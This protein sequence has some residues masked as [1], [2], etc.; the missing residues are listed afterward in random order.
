MIVDNKHDLNLYKGTGTIGDEKTMSCCGL[1]GNA[2]EQ[3][4]K[5][6]GCGSKAN[7]PRDN[8]VLWSK[9]AR[10]DFNEWI[11]MVVCRLTFAEALRLT[12]S[13]LLGSYHVYAV[14]NR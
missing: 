6:V 12:T 13:V 2:G 10:V 11:G 4:K 7:E 14:K 8:T 3:S 5:T 1:K 9:Y